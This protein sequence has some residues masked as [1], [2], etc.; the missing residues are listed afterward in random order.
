MKSR[1][2]KITGHEKCSFH[3][4]KQFD[5][6]QLR[7]LGLG[8]GKKKKGLREVDEESEENEYEFDEDD[9]MD[10]QINERVEELG[11]QAPFSGGNEQNSRPENSN[12]YSNDRD[13][14]DS[15]RGG[16]STKQRRN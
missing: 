5:D 2:I 10:Y 8:K 6:A 13:G 14:N 7:V 1:G 12:N 11:H 15:Y 4:L 9:E 16:G 3:Y